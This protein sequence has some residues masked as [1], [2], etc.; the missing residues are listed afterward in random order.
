M[1][2][3][4][5]SC[6][7]IAVV[8]GLTGPAAA[9][10]PMTGAEFEALSEGR[11][12]HFSLGGAPFGSEAFKSGR[13]SVWRFPDGTCAPGSWREHGGAICFV[14]DGDPGEQCWLFRREG[15]GVVAYFI[16]DGAPDE[17][18]VVLERVDRAPLA[19]RGPDV[20]A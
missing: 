2:P 8:L 5:Q 18:P 15:G 6:L 19:C 13:R 11:T 1:S 9:D 12:L 10:A 3:A 16:E 17:E 14:Y 20:G 7:A 4:L